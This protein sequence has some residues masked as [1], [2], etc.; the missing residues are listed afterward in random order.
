[1]EDYKLKLSIL[2]ESYKQQKQKI[3][4]ILQEKEDIEILN[5]KK[6]EELNQLS[7]NY[8]NLKKRFENLQNEL[9]QTKD[10]KKSGMLDWVMNSSIKDENATMKDKIFLLE[11]E[12]EFKIKENEDLHKNTWELKYEFESKIDALENK[13]TNLLLDHDKLK[14]ENYLVNQNLQSKENDLIIISCT[15]NKLKQ[16]LLETKEE[17]NNKILSLNS[18]EKQLID[19][20]S[21]KKQLV[22]MINPINE[23]KNKHNTYLNT[24]F[25]NKS[26]LNNS[27]TENLCYFESKIEFV[28]SINEIFANQFLLLKEVVIDKKEYRSILICYNK[29]SNYLNLLIL[30]SSIGFKAL[31]QIKQ[32][33]LDTDHNNTNYNEINTKNN[34]LLHY[35]KLLIGCLINFLKILILTLK[36]IS[37]KSTI[38]V[39][40]STNTQY[41][42]NVQHSSKILKNLVL[43][44]IPYFQLIQNEL[45]KLD[46]YLINSIDYK[47]LNISIIKE[48]LLSDVNNKLFIDIEAIKKNLGLIELN[49]LFEYMILNQINIGK[50]FSILSQEDK[51]ITNFNIINFEALLSKGKEYYK[52]NFS[53]NSDGDIKDFNDKIKKT[54][55]CYFK[56]QKI[57]IVNFNN[58]AEIT[59]LN[60]SSQACDYL[61]SIKF[62]MNVEENKATIENYE[63]KINTLS[64]SISYL[65]HSLQQKEKIIMKNKAENDFSNLQ[66]LS[67]ISTVSNNESIS[68]NVF[69]HINILNDFPHIKTEAESILKFRNEFTIKTDNDLLENK[70]I[71]GLI[72]SMAFNL[73]NSKSN[74]RDVDD[75]T[76]ESHKSK[77]IEL[78]NKLK[79]VEE[80]YS[81]ERKNKEG[82]EKN[83]SFLLVKQY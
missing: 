18:K 77:V 34:T 31:N 70:K 41:F 52:T 12:L 55:D 58:Q 7:F 21:H 13:L 3:A 8:N 68:L 80:D 71:Y 67:N 29:L 44:N 50:V 57:N 15:L 45:E 46:Y 23:Y 19:K 14:S 47:N 39:K 32:A 51:I 4:N 59:R 75:K 16:T 43:K 38:E 61:D 20:L 42:D 28:V 11:T 78:E 60:E 27:I 35:F 2:A 76:E 65:E 5:R 37:I 53:H 9:I 63:N 66:F 48:F 74:N 33:F 17:M 22:K 26:L 10:K 30:T 25:D 72:S 73:N 62:K 40:V 83:V 79:L 56:L 36:I 49:K 1:M 69:S 54:V 64:N 6:E 81:I 24:T 82:Y